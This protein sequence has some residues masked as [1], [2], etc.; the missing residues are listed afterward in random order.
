LLHAQLELSPTRR[1]AA[2]EQG[3]AAGPDAECAGI[4]HVNKALALNTA[5]PMLADRLLRQVVGNPRLTG[6]ARQLAHAMLTLLP[7]LP[8]RPAAGSRNDTE[9]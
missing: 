3:F 2:L 6:A 5:E 1:M 7:I 8:S 4:L 9:P